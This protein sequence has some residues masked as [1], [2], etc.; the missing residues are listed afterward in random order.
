MCPGRRRAD[1]TGKAQRPRSDGGWDGRW[2]F[3]LDGDETAIAVLCEGETEQRCR[4][5]E[6]ETGMI[7]ETDRA[8][9]KMEIARGTDEDGTQALMYRDRTETGQRRDET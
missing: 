9:L 2:W 8:D 3:E 7:P 1:T 5:K 4:R 6:D